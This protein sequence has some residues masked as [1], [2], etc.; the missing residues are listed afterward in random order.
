MGA[1]DQTDCAF[2]LTI[3]IASPQNEKQRRVHKSLPQP[4]KVRLIF[5]DAAVGKYVAEIEVVN[6]ALDLVTKESRLTKAKLPLVFYAHC[7]DETMDCRIFTEVIHNEKDK[8]AEIL[9][10]SSTK[11]ITNKVLN[12]LAY[13]A[14]KR[15][16]PEILVTD[17]AYSD[18]Y[19][20][21]TITA[22]V[23]LP[24]IRTYALRFDLTTT[25]SSVTEYFILPYIPSDE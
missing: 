19:C 23:D 8:R 5:D 20:K 17:F 12:K 4:L 25:T 11:Y 13:D 22:V 18:K 14:V 6:E 21:M 24:K 10:G 7:D 15:Q 2:C 1:L 16:Q 3:P 9:M